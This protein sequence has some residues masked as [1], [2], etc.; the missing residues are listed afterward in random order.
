MQKEMTLHVVQLNELDVESVL[1]TRLCCLKEIG[2]NFLSEVAEERQ[3][4]VQNTLDLGLWCCRQQYL[5]I[6]K[7]EDISKV[8]VE[9]GGFLKVVFVYDCSR[10]KRADS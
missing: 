8:V 1:L 4:F 9:F 6:L 5:P 2:F 7:L 3:P 10:L